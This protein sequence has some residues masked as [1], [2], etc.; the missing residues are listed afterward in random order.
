M[1][2]VCKGTYGPV[3]PEDDTSQTPCVQ[4][5][6]T[7]KYC[8]PKPVD[9]TC[10]PF[11]LTENRDACLI[12]GLVNE[13]LNI[14]G[15]N[16]N[17]FKLLGVHEQGKLVDVT[18]KG[19]AIANGSLP[20]FPASN[21]FDIYNT[22]WRS[23]QKGEAIIASSYLGYDF[24]EIKTNDE[25]RRMYGIETS[26]RK[27]ITAIALKQS[28]YSKNRITKARFERSEDGKKWY[29]VQ[30]II[31]P[32]DNCLNTFLI[33]D[34]VPSRYW[35]LRPLEFNGGSGDYWAIQAFQMFHDYIATN[36]DNI[37]DKVFMENRDRDYSSES[38]LLKGSYDLLE[39]ATELSRFGIDMSNQAYNIV[40]NFSACVAIL[41]RPLIIGDIMELPSEAMYTP[42]MELVKKWLEITDVSW[43]SSGYTP[44]WQPTLLRITA[45]PAFVSQETQDIFG[46][47][48]ENEVPNQLG[49]MDQ[50]DGNSK[51]YQDL[52]D[53][54]DTII[55]EAKND[56]PEAG[57]EGSSAVRQWEEEELAAAAEQGLLNLG[58]T[59]HRPTELYVED[60][61]PP[62]NAPFTEG[63]HFPPNPQHGDYHRVVYAGLS[64]D[65]P[66]RLYRYSVAKGRWVFLEKDKR[67]EHNPAK[68]TLEGYLI[69]KTRVPHTDISK[70]R[71]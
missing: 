24:G 69:S 28:N 8:P 39:S 23:I 60:A 12:D 66:A 16:L 37:Q 2:D 5:P 54:S 35:R 17:V 3:Y 40:I 31:L 45:Q 6:G 59:G 65:V 19:N 1:A 44:S 41:G 43:S 57:R 36:I 22:E 67:A 52:F 21:A 4:R 46:D 48:A 56:V 27:H 49:L 55:A 58:K 38:F 53:I 14:G 51:V 42:Q 20:N 25:S 9:L 26:V 61:M 18:G 10:K 30:S 68:P 50:Y 11:Q 63:E 15:A 47:L 29:G 32:D 71:P 13:H 33:K 34:S 70:E 64:K 7:D 62:N